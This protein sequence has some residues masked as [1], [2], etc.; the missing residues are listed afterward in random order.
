MRNMTPLMSGLQWATWLQNFV[1]ATDSFLIAHGMRMP[2]WRHVMLFDLWQY[3][4]CFESPEFKDGLKVVVKV[5]D[6]D[7]DMVFTNRV[8]T[9]RVSLSVVD[10]EGVNQPEMSKE[11]VDSARARF[12][13]TDYHRL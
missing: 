9:R 10:R 4:D 1:I 5:V 13:Y 11:L 12:A 7:G 6:D 3:D 8:E 2:T